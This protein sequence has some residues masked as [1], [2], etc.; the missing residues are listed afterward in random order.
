[1]SD[2]DVNDLMLLATTLL[3]QHIARNER[4]QSPPPGTEADW[5]AKLAIRNSRRLRELRDQLAKYN[6]THP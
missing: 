5:A 1:M 4:E 3:A 2:D 6:R